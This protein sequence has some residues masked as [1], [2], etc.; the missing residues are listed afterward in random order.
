MERDDLISERA[1]ALLLQHRGIPFEPEDRLADAV[2]VLG[3]KRP[4]FCLKV[5]PPPV[6][7]EVTEFDAPGPLDGLTSPFGGSIDPM[8]SVRRLRKKVHDEKPQLEPYGR[9]GHPTIIVVANPRHYLLPM[10]VYH[11]L[12]LFGEIATT[13]PF[14]GQRMVMEEAANVHTKNRVLSDHQTTYVSAVGILRGLPA[15]HPLL[16]AEPID[17]TRLYLRIVH[18]PF[19]IAPLDSKLFSASTDENYVYDRDTGS[20]VEASGREVGLFD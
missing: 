8:F 4:D 20:W 3:D 7:A 16:P 10:D 6:L 18:N 9:A 19:A 1:F 12:Q 11:V 14:D 17:P 5:G 2:T 15:T 13:M